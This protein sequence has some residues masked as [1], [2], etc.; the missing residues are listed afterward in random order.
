MNNNKLSVNYMKRVDPKIIAFYLPQYHPIKENDEWYGK[1]FTEWTNVAKAK[2][3]FK[4]HIQPKVPSDLGFYDLRIPE[5]RTA[6]AELAKE[7][8]IDAFCY[9]EYW[10]GN[11]KYLM[12]KPLQEVVRLKEPNFPFCICWANH[13]WYKKDWDPRMQELKQTLLMDQVYPGIDDIRNHF[14]HLLPAFKDTRYYKVDN[15]LLFVILDIK[16][17]PDYPLFKNTWN[18]LAKENGLP[19]FY[20]LSY[21]GRMNDVDK[22]PY[23][24]SEATILSLVTNIEYRNN[25]SKFNIIRDAIKKRLSRFLRIPLMVYSYKKAMKYLLNPVVSKENVI[26]VI[27][28][29]WDYTPRRGN[30]DLIFKDAKPEYFKEHVRQAIEYISDKPVEKQLLFLK[31]WN[32]WG[33]G[34]YMEPDLEFG[35]GRIEALHQILE[36]VRK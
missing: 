18:Q 3:C 29:N 6:Q 24:L 30:S 7:A 21:T 35:K 14:Y 27:V 5:V 15:R 1:G 22:E 33:E 16:S 31:S 36:E 19:D 26:P 12:E 11:G 8:G 2:P 13:R 20:F 9:Y 17:L 34:N 32:E 4:G 10:F 28:P 23:T 25:F